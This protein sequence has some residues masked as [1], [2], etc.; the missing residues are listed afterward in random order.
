MPT[1][2]DNDQAIRLAAFNALQALVERHGE[3]LPWEIIAEGFQL[4]GEQH[5]FANRTRG[6]FW[7]RQMQETALSIK[8]TVPR[9]S[10]VAR[11]DD[12]NIASDGAFLYKFQGTD[13]EARDNRRLLRAQQLDAPLIYFYGIEPGFYRPLWPVYISDVDRASH[14][15]HVVVSEPETVKQLQ[16]QRYVA[17][18]KLLPLERRY[19]TVQAKKRL[20][21]AAFRQHVLNA[22]EH[23]CAVCAFPRME[24][25]DGAHILPDRDER[26][27]AEVPN[28]L[29]LCRLH[30]GAFDT[31][32]MG[33]RPDGVIELAPSLLATRDGPTLEH[34]LK[35]FVGKTLQLPRAKEL[36]PKKLYLEERYERFRKVS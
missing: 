32:L 18:A 1:P 10:R 27:H 29:A 17:D 15:F 14:S 4:H 22:Y 19:T 3:V 35:G 24:L 23:R 7:P 8:T 26:G 6:I 11:Y 33:F 28:G 5:L 31:N 30:H 25:L 34:A 16:P 20:H 12:D 2:S 13:A 21:Q 36:R 9:G